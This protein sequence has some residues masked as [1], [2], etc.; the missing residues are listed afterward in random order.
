MCCS[1][2]GVP[3]SERALAGDLWGSHAP[4]VM[5]AEPPAQGGTQVL[6]TSVTKWD[7]VEEISCHVMYN[8][9]R[10]A[11][12]EHTVLLTEAFLNAKTNRARTTQIMFE[13]FYVRAVY[14]HGDP[15]RLVSVRF[16]THE[17]RCDDLW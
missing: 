14:V 2:R 5:A 9:L 7:D 15:D 8:E 13:T 4:A 11:P 17:A 3:T 12:E 1:P 16:E 6:G 10:I